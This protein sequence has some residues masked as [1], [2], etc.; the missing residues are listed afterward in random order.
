L[1]NRVPMLLGLPAKDMHTTVSLV[2][3]RT[4]GQTISA[5]RRGGCSPV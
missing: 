4:I 2:I 1:W 5:H 3:D